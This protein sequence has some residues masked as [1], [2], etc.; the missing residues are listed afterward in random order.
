MLFLLLS[1]REAKADIKSVVADY[2]DDDA[3]DPGIK[4]TKLAYIIGLYGLGLYLSRDSKL[5]N[6]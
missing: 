5:S 6:R 2:D 3:D 4:C 1:A